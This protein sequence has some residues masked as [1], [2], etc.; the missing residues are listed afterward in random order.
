MTGLTTFG[1]SDS[2]KFNLPEILKMSEMWAANQA[3]KRTLA[4]IFVLAGLTHRVRAQGGGDVE[5]V[6]STSLA[7]FAII[8]VL[9]LAV[10]IY[11]RISGRRRDNLY[12]STGLDLMRLRNKGLLTPE[13]MEKV[14]RS[15][16]RRLEEKEAERRKAAARPTPEA[17][18]LDPEVRRLQALAEAKEAEDRRS[19]PAP[20]AAERRVQ[21][22]QQAGSASIQA[23]DRQTAAVTPD[24]E[25]LAD[26]E[27]PLEVQQ[28]ADAGVLTPEEID[29]VKRRLRDRQQAAE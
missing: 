14:S 19:A 3:P 27:L 6:I 20:V 21:E 13:E 24:N 16:A 26:I 1:T 15:I 23:E 29:N 11:K 12:D 28:L 18:L 9:I 10:I 7:S 25:G 4:G 22:G 17:L 5:K 8:I 2:K